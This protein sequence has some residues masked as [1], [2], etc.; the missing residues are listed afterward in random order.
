MRKAAPVQA[1]EVR[2]VGY[3]VAS[4][5]F[6]RP[7]W[8]L[9]DVSLSLPTGGALALI[10][11]NGA[12]KTTLL[13]T[14]LGCL[15]PHQGEVLLFGRRAADPAARSHMGFM[16]ER[17]PFAPALRAFEVLQQHAQLVG[18][19]LQAAREEAALRLDQV[20]L[21]QAQKLALR[22]FSKG[23]LQ[24]L[25]LAQALVGTPRLLLLDEPMSGLDPDGRLRVRDLL[26]GQRSDGT[27]LL[28]SSHAMADVE[29]LADKVVV[30]DEGRIIQDGETQEVLD[31]TAGSIE[32]VASGNT[33]VALLRERL[34]HCHIIPRPRH[35]IC[36]VPCQ[37]DADCAIDAIRQGGGH[38]L[39]VTRRAPGTR[40]PEGL[41]A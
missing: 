4:G 33:R 25:A 12:G 30:M 34:P 23:M 5:L 35:T 9:R 41:D 17:P 28:F 29:L 15:R 6:S 11:A 21:S 24:R 1:V 40:A 26:L 3:K 37:S 39:R 16:P 38:V 19:G 8:L 32:I 14:M 2:H 20:G 31:G 18:F 36:E 10:G 22:A 13:K 27:T 7:R